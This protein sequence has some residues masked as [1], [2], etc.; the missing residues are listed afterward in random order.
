MKKKIKRGIVLRTLAGFLAVWLAFAAVS[1]ALLARQAQDALYQ[2]LHRAAALYESTMAHEEVQSLLNDPAQGLPDYGG[3]ITALCYWEPVLE[4][5]A[6]YQAGSADPKFTTGCACSA[7]LDAPYDAATFSL[8]ELLNEE[9]FDLL[10]STLRDFDARAAREQ[11]ALGEKT[12]HLDTFVSGW[13]RGDRLY[14]DRL[15]VAKQMRKV[16]YPDG[17]SWDLSDMEIVFDWSFDPEAIWGAAPGGSGEGRRIDQVMLTYDFLLHDTTS[18]TWAD[19][20]EM[21]ALA[22]DQEL[23]AQAAAQYYETYWADG[24]AA[25]ILHEG[26]PR[27]QYYV[28]MAYIDA[29]SIFAARADPL[30]DA[31]PKIAAVW[32]VSLLL[33]LSAGGLVCRGLCRAYDQ[34]TALEQNR[35]ET[36]NALAHD[37]K[38]PLALI[39]GYAENLQYGIK[40]EKH[41]HYSQ[42]IQQEAQRMDAI[43]GGFLE[44]SRLETGTLPLHREPL[45][46]RPFAE[47][48]AERYRETAELQAVALTVA[49]EGTLS[50]DRELFERALDNLL[51]NALR[52]TPEGGTVAVTVSPSGLAV[53]NTGKPIPPEALPHLFE[54]YYTGD[55]TRSGGKRHGL[56]LAIVRAIAELHGMQ[57]AAENT[58]TGAVLRLTLQ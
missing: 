38:T 25:L 57:A 43:L 37:L 21:I 28:Y 4:A 24:S 5:G 6:L 22:Q 39:R 3:N 29:E 44:L 10:L 51:S 19:F 42:Q 27:D 52:H 7:R 55:H 9:Q 11:H 16:I 45:P 33:V 56:G 54:A 18:Q 58:E 26:L 35:R 14:P 2:A 48:C 30:R 40:P 41:P 17:H 47:A 32:L 53:E 20:T 46:L 8:L 23:R 49:G 34:Q 15:I 12:A 31:L 36:A 50:A 1:G 13:V